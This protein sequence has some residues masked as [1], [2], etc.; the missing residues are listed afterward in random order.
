MRPVALFF[1]CLVAWQ[2]GTQGKKE[3]R[4][5]LNMLRRKK[6]RKQFITSAIR[7]PLFHSFPHLLFFQAEGVEEEWSV[8]AVCGQ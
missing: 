3:G 8:L 7:M 5:P 1:F 2:R 4:K 6:G